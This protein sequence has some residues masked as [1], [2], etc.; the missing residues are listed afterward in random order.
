MNDKEK[1]A[2]RRIFDFYEK[3]RSVI[4]ETDE[5]W[6]ELAGDVGRLGTEF[7]HNPLGFNLMTAALDTLN[8]LYRGGAK[9]VPE[10]Y[11][12]RDDL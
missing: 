7:A 11:F 8:T 10:G 6:G 1:E 9:P 4:I 3:W 5:Q 12:G 2:F